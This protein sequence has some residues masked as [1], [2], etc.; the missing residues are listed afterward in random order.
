MKASSDLTELIQARATRAQAAKAEQM[1]QVWGITKAEVIRRLIDRAE[2]MDAMPYTY[3][4]LTLGKPGGESV[5][6]EAVV[7]D[8]RAE[9]RALRAKLASQAGGES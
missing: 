5:I 8:V 4:S 9:L 6:D 7:D 3:R 2:L 1:G